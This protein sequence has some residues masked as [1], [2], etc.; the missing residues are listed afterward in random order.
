M[1][2]RH[3]A[4]V[5]QQIGASCSDSLLNVMQY[6]NNENIHVPV[7]KKEPRNIIIDLNHIEN[8]TKLDASLGVTRDSLHH[9]QTAYQNSTPE[10]WRK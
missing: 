2:G 4:E 3:G 6:N 1:F 7:I 10:V 9:V 5:S 8:T